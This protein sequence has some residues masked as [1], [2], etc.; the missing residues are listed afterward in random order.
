MSLFLEYGFGGRVMR[1]QVSLGTNSAVRTIEWKG[2]QGG[3]ASAVSNPSS[4]VLLVW[5]FPSLDD[6][7]MAPG[8]VHRL[9][10]LEQCEH[11][12]VSERE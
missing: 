4:L 5:L 8:P 12:T 6:H 7:V 9:L 1:L 11:S 3:R 2:P 10:P